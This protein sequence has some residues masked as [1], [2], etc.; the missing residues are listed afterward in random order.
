MNDFNNA[1]NELVAEVVELR[2]RIT[3]LETQHREHEASESELKTARDRFEYLLAF[4]PAIIYTTQSSG[5]FACT[6]VT[7]NIRSIM[8][9]APQDMTTDAKC[10][11]D[12]LHPDDAERVLS[13]LG[14][15]IEQGGGTVEYRFQHR[16]GHYVWI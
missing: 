2:R 12:K 7:E 6:Y 15:L 5:G 13:E 14:P 1:N 4:S 8:G 3:E 9:F 10:W 11:P 16:D